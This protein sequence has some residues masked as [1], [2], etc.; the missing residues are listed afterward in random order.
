MLGFVLT[1][2][3]FFSLTLSPSSLYKLPLSVCVYVAALRAKQDGNHHHCARLKMCNI[4][5]WKRKCVGKRWTIRRLSFVCMCKHAW[6]YTDKWH[7][8]HH[9]IEHS[10]FPSTYQ[11]LRS[12]SNADFVWHHLVIARQLW[13][14]KQK[15][16]WKNISIEWRAADRRIWTMTEKSVVFGGSD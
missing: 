12:T 11:R 13:N 2:F 6:V 15:L 5:W 7:V 14:V 8:H 3:H 9:H 16:K 4:S 1:C 10:L